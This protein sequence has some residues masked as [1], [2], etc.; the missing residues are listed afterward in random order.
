VAQAVRIGEGVLTVDSIRPA[1]RLTY[2]D[3][4]RTQRFVLRRASDQ[5]VRLEN[6]RIVVL[7]TTATEIRLGLDAP[8]DVQITRSELLA[9]PE[10]GS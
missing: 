3:S 5:T 1:V 6:C 2:K 10:D 4:R 7:D 9:E 8:A